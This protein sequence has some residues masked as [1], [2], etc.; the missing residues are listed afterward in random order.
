[1]FYAAIDPEGNPIPVARTDAERL[2]Q[3]HIL[4][5]ALRRPGR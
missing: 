5:P 4:R 3:H 2:R 1:M